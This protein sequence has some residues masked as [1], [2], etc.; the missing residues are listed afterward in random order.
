MLRSAKFV[1]L[2]SV[3]FLMLPAFA[4]AQN[5]ITLSLADIVGGGNGT[6]TGTVNTGINPRTGLTVG[7]ITSTDN[8]G[9]VNNFST[10]AHPFID[11]VFVPDG[12]LAAVTPISSTG[13][14]VNL[15]D[16]DGNSWENGMGY[17]AACCGGTLMVG[18][19]ATNMFAG[20]NRGIGFHA[21]K[22]ITFDLDAIEAANPGFY[23]SGFSTLADANVGTSASVG[24]TALL[25]GTV[26]AQN[27]ALFN[28]G[29]NAPLFAFNVG[30]NSRFLT[31]VG[32]DQGG[33]GGDQMTLGNP[34]V[35]LQRLPEP[36]SILVWT[37]AGGLMLGFA[38]RRMLRVRRAA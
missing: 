5:T 3:C 29:A 22:G 30:N 24:F 9:A 36:S 32:T 7:P 12:G 25:D 35:T 6:G 16:T 14:T 20:G 18:G 2:L 8:P 19:V 27:L 4:W 1:A 31:L 38:V 33:Y 10:V 37:L 17:N 21:N 34:T 15:P 26:M 11:G 28:D 23:V 13:I